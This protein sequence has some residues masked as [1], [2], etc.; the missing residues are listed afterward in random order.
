MHHSI[1]YVEFAAPKL[2]ETKAFF[3]E[4]FGWTF[5]DYGPHYAASED[6]GVPTGFHQRPGHADADAGSALI[7]LYSNDLEASLL[8]VREAGC[9]IKTEIFAFPGGRRFHFI[10]PSGNELAVWSDQEP[11]T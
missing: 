7:V 4:V 3:S 1:T 2:S 11:S 6:C 8:A 5:T 9:T 10:E